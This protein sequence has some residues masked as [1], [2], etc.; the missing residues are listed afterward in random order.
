MTDGKIIQKVPYKARYYHVVIGPSELSSDDLNICKVVN[1]ELALVEAETSSFI[2]AVSLAY[3][4]N[5][6]YEEYLKAVETGE[7]DSVLEA[8]GDDTMPNLMSGPRSLQ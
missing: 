2:H 8:A 7:L 6:S 1:I 3:N 5:R 4:M